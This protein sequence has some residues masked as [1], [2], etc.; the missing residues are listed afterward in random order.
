MATA[1][2]GGG[3]L[4]QPGRYSDAPV[5]SPVQRRRLGGIQVTFD[6]TQMVRL[7][8]VA[9]GESTRMGRAAQVAHE[10]LAKT[11]SN[12]IAK[13]LEEAVDDKDRVQGMRR[14]GRGGRKKKEDRLANV[15]RSERNRRVN[16]QG[17]SVGY[18]DEIPS[19][20]QYYRGLEHGSRAHVGRYL[21]GVFLPGGRGANRGR[22]GTVVG[23]K[24]GRFTQAAAGGPKGW[25]TDDQKG[26]YFPGVRIKKRIIGYQYFYGGRRNFLS[27][28]GADELALR[29][30]SLAFR[31]EGM[32]LLARQLG[33]RYGGLPT[34]GTFV[35][36]GR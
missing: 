32:D 15:I 6:A 19:V 17:Y 23:G 12:H 7:T 36:T 28:G 22:S 34:T 11:L 21:S 20:A 5:G 8:N 1:Y 24:D 9:R 14:S 18:L 27:R 13:V 10:N 3:G 2:R 25:H 33:G 31:K 4:Y 35:D 26:P 29:H 16:Q 30:Y